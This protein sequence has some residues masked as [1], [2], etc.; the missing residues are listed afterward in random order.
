MEI[1]LKFSLI[2]IVAPLLIWYWIA[3]YLKDKREDV[4]MYSAGCNHPMPE[5]MPEPLNI[6]EPIFTLVELF[7]ANPTSFK[8][9]KIGDNKY[10]IKH[11]QSGIEFNLD[12]NLAAY[13]ITTHGLR[14]ACSEYQYYF[15]F[16]EIDLTY[17]EYSLMNSTVS[18]YLDSIRER[19]ERIS[20]IR[21]NKNR[22]IITKKL[23]G[24]V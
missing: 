20:I 19:R 1:Y 13:D 17:D 5:P 9:T 3:W 4:V 12:V 16:N 10:L 6:S 11:L 23:K 18:E 15:K 21:E 22:E 24:R 14:R 8:R 7:K 2:F